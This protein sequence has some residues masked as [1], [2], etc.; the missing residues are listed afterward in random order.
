[1]QNGQRSSSDRS[2]ITLENVTLAWKDK[3]ILKNISGSFE[4]GSLTAVLGPNG[5]GKSTLIKGM[6]GLLKPLSGKIT[7]HPHLSKA[8][9]PQLSEV[10]RN[11]P[12]TVYDLVAMGAWRHVGLLRRYSR[13]M[14]Y[15][16]EAAIDRV[17]LSTFAQSLVGELS[18]G[19]FQRALFARL[20]LTDAQIFILDEPF[21]S[22]DTYTRDDLLCIIRDW[23]WEGRTVIS[24]L[25]DMDIARKDFDRCLLLSREV[26]AWGASC[27]VVTD[28][29]LSVAREMRGAL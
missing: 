4:Q 14:R 19:Q 9:L 5:A 3:P 26:V 20:M 6:V 11:F 22:V 24:V 15:R 1:M 28:E 12:M 10:D 2:A 27:D 18:G 8:L 13:E 23:Q 21:A 25:H 17:G 29:N 7:Y 16:I